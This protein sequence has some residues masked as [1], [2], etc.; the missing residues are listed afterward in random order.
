MGTPH[1]AVPPL[2]ALIAEGINVVAVVTVADKPSGRGQKL[3]ESPVKQKALEFNIPIL[4]P[5]S[6]KDDGFIEALRSYEA[7]L[8]IVVAFRMLPKRVWSMPP[9][10]TFNLHGSLLPAYR[11]AAPIN[12]AVINGESKTGLTTFLLDEEIDT[13]KI[14]MQ[15]EM[16][17]PADWTAGELHDSLMPMGA[18]MVVETTKQIACGNISPKDQPEELATHAPK[19]TKE[20]CLLDLTKDPQAL[21]QQIK[22]LSP[23]PGAYLSDYKFLNASSIASTDLSASKAKLMV[24]EKKLLLIYSKGAIEITEIKAAG[25]RNMSGKDF[26]NGMK[27]LEIQLNY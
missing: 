27:T 1:F 15:E 14:L 20:N 26:I 10:G 7:D 11:G 4:Q 13:G 2:E 17:I 18:R 5:L 23:F 21:V 9:L 22:G 19:L 12:W 3:Q 6:L 8:F 16:K 24:F 25:K